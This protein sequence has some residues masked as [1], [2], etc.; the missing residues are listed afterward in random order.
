MKLQNPSNGFLRLEIGSSILLCDV[1]THNGIYEGGWAIHPPVEDLSN[2]LQGCTHLFISHIHEDHFDLKAIAQ[3]NKSTHIIIPDIYPNH[4]IRKKIIDIG[5]DKI[6]ML[7]TEEPTKINDDFSMEAIPPM[8]GFAQDIELY[9][10]QKTPVF[11]ADAG[12]LLYEN[13]RKYVFLFDNSPYHLQSA[14]KCSEHMKSADLMAFPY[15]GIAQ[16]YPICYIDINDS[17]MVQIANQREE[18]RE[19]AT[20]EFLNEM[21]PKLGL[22]F[23]SDFAVMGPQAKRFCLFENEWWMNKNQVAKRYENKLSI[24][25]TAL[26]MD[27]SIEFKDNEVIQNIST[28]TPPTL[29]QVVLNNYSIEPKTLLMHRSKST[30]SELN[31]LVKNASDNMFRVMNKNKINTDWILEFHL[32]GSVDHKYVLDLKNQLLIHDVIENRK[33]LTCYIDQ[34]YFEAIL[35]RKSHWNN[36]QLSFQLQWKRTPNEFDIFLYGA[37]NFFHLPFE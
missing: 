28:Y 5:F 34:A 37:L 22:P 11:A 6:T 8:N 9:Q 13:D 17:E 27:D 1:W 19:K 7:S 30:I 15:N 20:L 10:D 4:V 18:K 24:P 12:L 16:D 21:K 35:K 31:L 3:L 36:A 2:Y 29:S 14:G 23:S 33:V 32:S 26:N 25:M